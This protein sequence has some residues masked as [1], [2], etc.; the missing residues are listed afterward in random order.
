MNTRL[1]VEHPVTE[2]VTGLD[3]VELQ[4][5]VAAGERLALAQDDVR[6]TGHAIEARIYAEDAYG[7]F[8][9]QAGTV[10]HVRW[11]RGVRVDHALGDGQVVT[12]AYDPM[13]A[14]VIAHGPDR[15]SARHALVEALDGT[16]ILGLT[17]NTG[18]L[19]TLADSAEFRDAAV[20]TAWLD[21]NV[22]PAP[23]DAAARALAGQVLRVALESEP[24]GPWHP[25]GFRLGGPRGPLTEHGRDLSATGWF[26]APRSAEGLQRVGSSAHGDGFVLR[27]RHGTEVVVHGQRFVLDEPDPWGSAAGMG[28]GA[29]TAP[30]P[31]TVL[32]VRVAEGDAV[33]EG[34]VLGVLEAMKMELSLKAPFAGTV[35]TVGA[36]QGRQV[37]LG[38]TLFVVEAADGPA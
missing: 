15:E 17:T 28:D 27:G 25:D 7:G 6:T 31:G 10:T 37:A 1:Q 22:L 8:L 34:Q 32:D 26:A 2:L 30:M 24:P 13:L 9:P 29:L 12:T 18:F 33:E 5:R 11:P 16:A 19:R 20:D 3:L 35:A 14:K 23:D 38:D 21:R 36:Q 4:L